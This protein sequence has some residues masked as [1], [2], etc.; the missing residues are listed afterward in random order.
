MPSP[1][2]STLP[3]SR[4]STCWRYCS[5]SLCRTETISSALNLMAA[6]RDELVLDRFEPRLQRQVVE[7]VADLDLQPAEQVRVHHFDQ[8][9]LHPELLAG[10][11]LD[12]LA[13]LVVE[14][15]GRAHLEADPAVQRVAQLAV[16]RP[17]RPDDVEAVVGAEHEQE[18]E[19]QVVDAAAERVADHLPAAAP[20]DGAAGQQRGDVGP[21]PLA[22]E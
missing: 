9:R 4:A 21:A 10:R 14:R 16:L 12:A 3:T 8:D 7:Q 6:S 18:V 17:D 1:T 5:I 22:A 20:R 15:H 2:S 19:E 13:L 11:R